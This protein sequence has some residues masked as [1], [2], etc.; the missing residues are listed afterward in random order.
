MSNELTKIAVFKG[1]KVRKT[2]HN[3]EWWFSII[4][5]IEVLTDSENPRD[6]WYKM[7]IREKESSEV[8]LSTICRQLK[9]VAPDGKQRETDCADTEG[10][11]RI[12]QSIPSP[13]AEPFKRWLAKVGFERI[14]EIEDPELATKRTRLLYK[15][16]GY[17]DAWIEKRMRGIAIREE[18][19]EE[20]QNR[21]A[22]ED[23]DYEVL[24][25]EISKATFGITPAEYKDLKG[26]KSQNLRDHM[27]DFELIFTMLGERSTTEIHRNEDSKGI[28]KLKGDA[29]AGGAIAGGA[30]QQLEKRLGR[31]VVS[32]DNFLKTPEDKKLSGKSKR[33]LK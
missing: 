18:L 24:T 29:Q 17:S 32:K 1:K 10:M 28:D 3:N 25:A 15:L 21:G 7:K 8:E 22:N 31:S 16:K 19:T 9:L 23:V 11:F 30:R 26:L 12:I 14:K 4:D 13:K 2:I 33:S 6:Y 27:D 20:W 5:V